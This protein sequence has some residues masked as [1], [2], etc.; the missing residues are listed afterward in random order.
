MLLRGIFD[1]LF[2]SVTKG[3][4]GALVGAIVGT[5]SAL[6]VMSIPIYLEIGIF[7]DGETSCND[8][9]GWLIMLAIFGASLGAILGT[10]L[11]MVGKKLAPRI[12]GPDRE[13][14]GSIVGGFIGG[15]AP[16]LILLILSL[17]S[18]DY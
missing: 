8:L 12:L 3:G 11:G 1:L 5:V 15:V 16:W 18:G 14:A 4:Y 10:M 6:A 17:N 13:K 7:C 2:W 9:R